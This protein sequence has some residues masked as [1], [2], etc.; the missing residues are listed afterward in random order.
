MMTD[1]FDKSDKKAI[2]NDPYEEIEILSSSEQAVKPIKIKSEAEFKA[3]ISK[4]GQIELDWGRVSY[5]SDAPGHNSIRGRE[6]IG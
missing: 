3:L 4:F 5:L 6:R 1:F 2:L